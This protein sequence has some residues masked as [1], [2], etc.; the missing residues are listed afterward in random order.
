MKRRI[1]ILGEHGQVARALASA[2][3]ARGDVLV[4][5]GR[6]AVDITDRA[7]LADKIAAFR[8]DLIVNAA[9]YTQVDRAEDETAQA[10]AVNRDGARNAAAAAAKT[11]APLIHLSTDYVFDGTK[12]GPYLE[13]DTPNPVSV[14]GHSKLA[15]EAALADETDDYLIVRTSWVYSAWGT[16]F[17][18]T[19]LRL[20]G[21]RDE[22]R[23]V[24][25]Q[26][27]SPT[28]APHLAEALAAIGEACMAGRGAARQGLY[29][30]AGTGG[31]TWCGFARAIMAGSAARGGPAARVRAITSREFPTRAR[32]P[33]NSRLNCT[34]AAK[35]F[36][37]RLPTWEASLD[38]CLDALVPVLQGSEA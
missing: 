29:H 34:K 9:G 24:D 38:N 26:R 6:A 19:M 31:T 16:N 7:A 23:V 8:P 35:V 37:I 1:F 36:G 18:R 30:L 33:A 32:R 4:C 17:V 2:C 14:Y 3:A 25:D 27:G 12:S 11:G 20:A 28:F 21:G 5:A 10:F 13:T 22:V 15:G